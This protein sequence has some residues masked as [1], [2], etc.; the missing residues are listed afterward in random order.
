MVASIHPRTIERW[1][2]Q[3]SDAEGVIRWSCE[4]DIPCLRRGTTTSTGGPARRY[5]R[6]SPLTSGIRLNVH[7]FLSA[8]D[9]KEYP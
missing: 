1:I 7:A 2:C 4:V 3:C 5:N 6:A 9:R 8:Q